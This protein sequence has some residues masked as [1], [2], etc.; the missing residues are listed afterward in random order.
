MAVLMFLN[1]NKG[2]VTSFRVYTEH[3]LAADDACLV[4]DRVKDFITKSVIRSSRAIEA[5][6]VHHLSTRTQLLP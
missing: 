6:S 2:F 4:F 5:N 3:E 1:G